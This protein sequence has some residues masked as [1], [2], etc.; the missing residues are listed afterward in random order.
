MTKKWLNVTGALLLMSVAAQAQ[1][2]TSAQRI[3]VHKDV[4]TTSSGEVMLTPTDSADIAAARSAG[5]WY[6]ASGTTCSAVDIGEARN[7]QFDAGSY[8]AA[9][10]ISPDSAKHIAL[11]AVPGQIGSGEMNMSGNRAE[12]EIAIIPNGKKTYSKVIVDAQT[13][14][15]LSTKQFGG[16]RGV[17]GWARESLEHKQNTP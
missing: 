4:V 12:Y 1:Y 15:V 6:V 11:C 9:T 5:E 14:A 13:G 17:A 16:L 10:M 2:A 7:V 8:N 3:P